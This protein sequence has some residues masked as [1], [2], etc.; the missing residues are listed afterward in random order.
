[1]KSGTIFSTLGHKLLFTAGILA[2]LIFL[3]NG[4]FLKEDRTTVIY[5]TVTDENKQPVDSIL[6]L[7]IGMKFLDYEDLKTVYTDK[8]GHYEL[9]VEVPKKF[10]PVNV[11]I[12]SW[13]I[14]NPKFVRLYKEYNVLKN[15]EATGNCCT[16]SV[17]EKTKYDFQ[18][19]AK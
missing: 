18:L 19:I 11:A 2:S 12:P 7:L 5:G 8:Q 3:L 6:V 16:A 15:D 13:T 10:N 4:C 17:G 1:M 14:Q 9:V